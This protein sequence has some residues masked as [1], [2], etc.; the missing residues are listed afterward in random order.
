MTLLI[1]ITGGIGS[2]KSTFSKEVK[3]RGFKLLDSDQIVT[4]IYKKPNKEFINHLIRIGLENSIKNK[5][6]NKKYISEII[7]SNKI[8]KSKLEKYIFKSI[9]RTRIN[10]IKKE[11]K[12]KTK[13]IFFD[14]PLLFENELNKD[15][16]LIISIISSKKERYK[17]LKRNKNISRLLFYKIIKSQTTDLIRKKNSDIVI[18]NNKDKIRYLNKINKTLDTITL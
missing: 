13:F 7:F 18:I 11:K 3:K 16:D 17:R 12:K 8:I 9:K 4:N 10:F 2:G 15:F 5:K 1:A 6:I 14:I